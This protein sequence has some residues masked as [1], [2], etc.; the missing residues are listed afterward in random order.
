[1]CLHAVREWLVL[2]TMEKY[3]GKFVERGYDSL[4]RCK[5][6]IASDLIVMGVDDPAH[7]KLLLDGVQFLINAP[8]K[9]ICTEPCELHNHVELQLDPDVEFDSLKSLE[10]QDFPKVP[11]ANW[12]TSSPKMAKK[13]L[14]RDFFDLNVKE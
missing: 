7:R 9:F 6:I 14:S 3:A 11:V 13:G 10:N 5:L 8:E 2:L 12:L 4:A 1:M